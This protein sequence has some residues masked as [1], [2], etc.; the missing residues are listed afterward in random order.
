MNSTKTSY[1]VY[2]DVIE[3]FESKIFLRVSET[4]TLILFPC[5]RTESFKDKILFYTVEK[6]SY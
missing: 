3:K 5:D 4:S 6:P 1:I 2:Y